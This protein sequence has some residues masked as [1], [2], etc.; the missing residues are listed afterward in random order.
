MTYLGHPYLKWHVECI[1]NNITCK[2]GAFISIAVHEVDLCLHET[3]R[4]QVGDANN[5]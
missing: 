2:L 1:R 4:E 5:E 3:T